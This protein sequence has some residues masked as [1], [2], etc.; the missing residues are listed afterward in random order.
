MTPLQVIEELKRIGDIF[1]G[2]VAG[3][4]VNDDMLGSMEFGC[5]ASGA[6]LVLVLGHTACGAGLSHALLKMSGGAGDILR[7]ATSGSV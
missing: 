5:A 2:R 6:K 7:D 3:N 1:T 4:I